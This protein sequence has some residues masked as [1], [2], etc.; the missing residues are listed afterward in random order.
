MLN[1]T[2]YGKIVGGTLNFE[3]DRQIRHIKYGSHGFELRRK[4]FYAKIYRGCNFMGHNFRFALIINEITNFEARSI[5]LLKYF[6]T[7]IWFLQN[8]TKI[9]LHFKSTSLC[10]KLFHCQNNLYLLYKAMWNEAYLSTQLII[11][12]GSIFT[13]M[14]L[15][16]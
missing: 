14:L 3:F 7:M 9:S 10:S 4:Y 2:K 11:H 15:V 16:R 8:F 13:I 6:E 12:F 1:F 5:L